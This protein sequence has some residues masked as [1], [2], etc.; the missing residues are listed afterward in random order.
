MPKSPG[1]EMRLKM[2]AVAGL[3][4]VLGGGLLI[5]QLFKLQFTNSEIYKQRAVAQQLRTTA[6]SAERGT[7]YD[8]NG[9]VLAK[10]ATVWTVFISPAEINEEELTLIADNLSEIL[11]VDRQ[12]IIDR[13]SNKRSYYQIIKQKIDKPTADLVLA[14]ISQHKLKGVN[15]EED[16]KRYYPYGNFA[17][18]LI[19]FTGSENKGAYGLE[20]YY[21]KVLSGTPGRVVSAK[22]ALGKDMPFRYTEMFEA[23][24][25]NSIVLTIDEVIQHFL[26]KNLETAVNEHQIKNR[27]C[28]IV[29]DVNTGA[30]L[31]M[32]TKPDFDPNEPLKL[33][34]PVAQQRLAAVAGNAELYKETLRQ[35]QFMQWANKAI[36]E[37]Y[38]PGSVA[39]II[40]ASAAV[41]AGTTKLD[42][43]FFCPGFHIVSGVRIRCHKAGGHGAQNFTQAMQNSC[44]PAFMMIGAALGAKNYYDFFTAFGMD[45]PTGIDLPGEADNKS[46]TQPFNLLNKPGGVELASVSFGQSFKVTPIQMI[47]AVSAAVNGGKLYQ[48]YVVKQVL[49]SDGNILS[50]TQPTVKRQVLSEESSA[51]MRLLLE[52]VVKE[53]SGR[54]AKIPGYRVG[55]KTGTS[56]KLDLLAQ[57]REENILSFVGVAPMDNPK[58]A[59]LV[60]LD[61]PYVRN[62]FGSVIAA[63]VVGSVLADI[64]PY[65]GI[66]PQYTPEELANIDISVPSYIAQMPH[67]AQTNLTQKG[68]KARVIGSGGTVVRQIPAAGQS[69]PRGGMVIL[70]TEE[71]AQ[72]TNVLI[73]NV[74]G[75]TGQQAMRS[76]VNSGLNIR[77]SGVDAQLSGATAVKQTP[78][79]GLEVEPGTVVTVTI[80]D[81]EQQD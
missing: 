68:L 18:Q 49:D 78:E 31:A 12:L 9:K 28:G 37:P 39:K 73:P 74:V 63:P 42:D 32:A 66:Q 30:I 71:E 2:L 58:V 64:L 70:Y 23:Q 15:L 5:W 29:M 59:V 40:T 11:Q 8:T 26:E 77:I 38:E 20:A 48:P 50:T 14:F 21:N 36:A 35:E 7:I 41:E 61:E 75:M 6:I 33:L 56:Q 24:D 51:T 69:I 62:V 72:A 34:D 60:L 45:S 52:M 19:G 65:M 67:D 43:H 55:G 79:A 1:N 44:N 27:A 25:G 16:T 17:A 4:T 80:I 53:G 47:T 22:N 13:G 76:I 57:G 3:I 46:L 10:S 81:T 54:N